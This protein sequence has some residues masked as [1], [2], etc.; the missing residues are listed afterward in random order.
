MP[1]GGAGCNRAGKRGDSMVG[2]G[3]FEARCRTAGGRDVV[4]QPAE[5]L[6]G[7]P[8][9]PTGGPLGWLA[10]AGAGRAPPRAHPGGAQGETG[11]FHRDRASEVPCEIPS[12]LPV[13]G[14]LSLFHGMCLYPGKSITE[15]TNTYTWVLRITS[16]LVKWGVV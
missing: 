8:A 2:G 11:R 15:R 12:E 13:F 7:L 16:S 14:P 4:L 10:G 3:L 5:L 6:G 9:P 1:G